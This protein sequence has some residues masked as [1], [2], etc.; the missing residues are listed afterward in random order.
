ML[1]IIVILVITTFISNNISNALDKGISFA[2]EISEGNLKATLDLDQKDEIGELAFA[3][4]KMASK[5]RDIVENINLSAA[6]I[7]SA[8]HQISAGAQQ[9]SQGANQQASTAEEVS[10]SMEEMAANIQ[11]NT[12]NAVQ[13][14]KISME[15]K[16]SMDLMGVSGKNSI[17]SIKD[18]AS[19]ITII[20]DIA[21]QTNILALNAAVEA[22]RAGDHGKGFAVV[23]SEVRKLAEKK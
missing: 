3:L 15:A 18:I 4:K 17:H 20:N 14:G 1:C 6:Q 23:A 7:A 16:R 8:S 22:A 12:E 11:Q 5:L 21:F 9:L 10:S 2:K 19:K 13:T